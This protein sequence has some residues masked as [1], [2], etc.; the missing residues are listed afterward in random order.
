MNGDLL[1]LGGGQRAA[2]KTEI[3]DRAPV[4]LAERRIANRERRRGVDRPGEMVFHGLDLGFLPVQIKLDARSA[5]RAIVVDG[6][7]MPIANNE[8]FARAHLHGIIGPLMNQTDVKPRST[9]EVR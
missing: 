2:V 4:G 5:A 3:V 1:D 6:H 7:M 8:R 9:L